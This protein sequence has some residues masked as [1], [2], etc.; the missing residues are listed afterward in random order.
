MNN[1]Y[2]Y[3]LGVG[4][5]CATVALALYAGMLC[6]RYT[7]PRPCITNLSTSSYPYFEW[8]QKML[9]EIVEY[10][11]DSDMYRE[12]IKTSAEL[13]HRLVEMSQ[14]SEWPSSIYVNAK[15]GKEYYVPGLCYVGKVD[16]RGEPILY[17]R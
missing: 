15:T 14:D 12:G 7:A 5:A 8:E 9:D 17:R 13:A 4:I 1:H 2:G 16:W 10:S 11:E 3:I 6:E